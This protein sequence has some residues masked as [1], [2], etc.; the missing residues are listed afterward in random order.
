MPSSDMSTLGTKK[1]SSASGLPFFGERAGLGSGPR[2]PRQAA[3]GCGWPAGT[4]GVLP[5]VPARPPAAHASRGTSVRRKCRLLLPATAGRA[6]RLPS[7]P[8][9]SRP[10]AAP[11][12]PGGLSSP[13]CAMGRGDSTPQS[14][15]TKTVQLGFFSRPPLRCGRVGPAALTSRLGVWTQS[16]EKFCLGPPQCLQEP[17]FL[18][19]K[20]WLASGS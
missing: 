19:Q 6:G 12:S 11:P 10:P 18:G 20:V 17:G 8:S 14:S 13:I 3:R 4:G 2:G 16:P 7:S 5:A 9:D 1:P 15:V